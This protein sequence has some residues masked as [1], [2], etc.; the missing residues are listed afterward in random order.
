V[1]ARLGGEEFVLILPG[2]DAAA[3]AL[4]CERVRRA[5]HDFGWTTITGGLPV[6]SS[7][8]VTTAAPA[9]TAAALL[10]AADRNLY[11]AKRTGRDRVVV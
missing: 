8:G 3:A 4:Y 6:T 10:A 11:V 9:S 7:I 2:L 1:A 5:I